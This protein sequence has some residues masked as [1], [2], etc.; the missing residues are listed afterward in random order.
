MAASGRRDRRGS[1]RRH[2]SR[3]ARLLGTRVSGA[4]ST[5][6]LRPRAPAWR[7]AP[8]ARSRRRD[9]RA[10]AAEPAEQRG[11]R[12]GRGCGAAAGCC[13]H[14]AGCGVLAAHGSDR[15]HRQG[16]D[17]QPFGD[18]VEHAHGRRQP[19]QD[20]PAHHRQCAGAEQRR[21]RPHPPPAPAPRRSAPRRRRPARSQPK[22]VRRA[23]HGSPPRYLSGTNAAGQVFPR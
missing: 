20:Q 17:L 10:A 16:L 4:R 3:G 15:R 19:H 13:A 5:A 21:R 7:A 22:R 8:C 6:G 18:P 2:G 1:R 14:R 11:P 23:F 12:G 9:R